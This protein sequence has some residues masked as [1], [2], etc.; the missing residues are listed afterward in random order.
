M[1]NTRILLILQKM[2]DLFGKDDSDND[3]FVEVEEKDDT[4]AALQQLIAPESFNKKVEE[5]MEIDN[6]PLKVS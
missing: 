6:I 2:E 4:E 5:P 3:D 1:A